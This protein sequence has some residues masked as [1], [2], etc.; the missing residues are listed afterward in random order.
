M[1]FS[2]TASQW[3]HK[4]C[5]ESL[6]CCCHVFIVENLHVK[7]VILF[8]NRKVYVSCSTSMHRLYAQAVSLIYNMTRKDT[9]ISVTRY[10]RDCVYYS[11]S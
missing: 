6:V 11:T 1:D 5:S 3:E 9:T 2:G 4:G 10:H 7:T 8:F